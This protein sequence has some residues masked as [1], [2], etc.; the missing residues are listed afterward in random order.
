MGLFCP[1]SPAT[2]N[3]VWGNAHYDSSRWQI[4]NEFRY[5]VKELMDIVKLIS[6]FEYLNEHN[7]DLRNLGYPL[8]AAFHLEG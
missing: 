8:G 2:K 3:P 5:T 7:S 6:S 1:Y 4:I